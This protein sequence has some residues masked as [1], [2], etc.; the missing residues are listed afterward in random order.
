[1]DEVERLIQLFTARADAPALARLD[2][3]LDLRRHRHPRIVPFLLQVLMDSDESG[4]VRID[5]VKQLT[6]VPLAAQERS[7]VAHAIAR[8]LVDG[9]DARLRLQAAMA[10]GC[11]ADVEGIPAVLGSVALDTSE[12]VD[13]RFSSFTSLERAGATPESV[14]LVG[15]LTADE[16]LGRAAAALLAT[17]RVEPESD[18]ATQPHQGEPM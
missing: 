18:G 9:G 8:S 13:L 11:F 5:V 15:T 16:T 2:I 4:E 3:L 10:L 12:S 6:R 7:A 17:W 14:R 1:V